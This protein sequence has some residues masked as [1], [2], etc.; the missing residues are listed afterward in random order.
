MYE[1]IYILSIIIFSGVLIYFF[2]LNQRE[3]Q[4]EL[5]KINLLE[6]E[7]EM[8]NRR[9][10]EARNKT[11]PCQYQGL[12]TPRQCYFGSHHMC[13]WNTNTQRCDRK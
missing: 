12:N 5:D 7:E 11:T 10:E 2:I 6:K 8:N 1:Q 3:H 4:K 9:L 13:S